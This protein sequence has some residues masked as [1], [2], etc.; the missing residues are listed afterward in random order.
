MDQSAAYEVT[1]FFFGGISHKSPCPRL[2]KVCSQLEK[3]RAMLGID[4][5]N[6]DLPL[7]LKVGS[8]SMSLDYSSGRRCL[9]DFVYLML[10]LLLVY[11]SL[12]NDK[13]GKMC[14]KRVWQRH[15]E[16]RRCRTSLPAALID[17]KYMKP[18]LRRPRTMTSLHGM[19]ARVS[20]S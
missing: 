6:V 10:C 14:A 20:A 17:C 3:R 4:I 15:G 1:D 8:T 11:I 19:G 9:N 5:W 7:G 18:L 13:N 2:W 12:A 16:C